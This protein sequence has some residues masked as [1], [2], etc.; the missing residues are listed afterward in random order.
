MKWPTADFN[1][2]FRL[3]DNFTSYQT[4]DLTGNGT[5]TFS[6]VE[7]TDCDLT[8]LTGINLSNESAI[9]YYDCEY[10]NL[11]SLIQFTSHFCN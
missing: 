9:P 10:S 8:S 1:M 2:V 6:M 4:S 5:I 11:V 7:C 3:F